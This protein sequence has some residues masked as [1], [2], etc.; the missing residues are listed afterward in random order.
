VHDVTTSVGVL[1]VA[2]VVAGVG[3]A[4]LLTRR[5]AVTPVDGGGR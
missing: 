2:A 1:L 5:A 4:G 3:L